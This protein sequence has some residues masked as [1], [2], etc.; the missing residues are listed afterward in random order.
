MKK[1]FLYHEIIIKKNKNINI[2]KINFIFTNSF[3][4]YLIE[5]DKININILKNKSNNI[6]DN[7]ERINLFKKRNQIKVLYKINK[8][9]NKI[10]IFC[11]YFVKINIKKC[12]IVNDGKKYKLMEYFTIKNIKKNILKIR[13]IGINNVINL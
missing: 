7:N 6:R 13:L 4:N 9:E 10:K 12:Y 3:N 1:K 2:K 5:Y 8:E 11:D